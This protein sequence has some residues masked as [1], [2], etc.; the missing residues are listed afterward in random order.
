MGPI[1]WCP[2]RQAQ[3]DW[4]VS[5]SVGLIPRHLLL[6]SL[7][8]P[9]PVKPGGGCLRHSWAPQP[10]PHPLIQQQGCYGPPAQGY[11]HYWACFLW[12][13]F[14][15]KQTVN[16]R[17]RAQAEAVVPYEWKGYGKKTDFISHKKT[18]YFLGFIPHKT[19]TYSREQSWWGIM[20]WGHSLKQCSSKD[21]R[22]FFPNLLL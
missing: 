13:C 19:T 1:P 12:K 8:P 20:A 7:D 17:A 10:S 22:F 4:I 16:H 2:T 14:V 5:K 18:C 3:K 11:G 15:K 21:T 9:E 6:Q